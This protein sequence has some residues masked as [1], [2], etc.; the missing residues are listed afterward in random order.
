MTSHSL[1]IESNAR[2]ISQAAPDPLGIHLLSEPVCEHLPFSPALY[3]LGVELDDVAA[4]TLHPFSRLLLAEH[5]G[6]LTDSEFA[7]GAV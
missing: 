6:A 2:Y 4:I 5:S 1:C 3:L 7:H